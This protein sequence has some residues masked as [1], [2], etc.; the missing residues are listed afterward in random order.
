MVREVCKG[1]VL[2]QCCTF[3]V[4]R[5]FQRE[6]RRQEVELS[7]PILFFPNGVAFFQRGLECLPLPFLRFPL[8]IC[9]GRQ[10]F[11]SII[12][13]LFF[14]KGQRDGAGCQCQTRGFGG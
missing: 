5:F 4:I 13:S 10:L 8:K 9:R 3:G 12:L 14:A 7:T 11:L 1:K 6:L 2:W